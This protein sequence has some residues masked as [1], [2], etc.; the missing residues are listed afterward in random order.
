MRR[1]GIVGLPNAGKTTLFNALTRAGAHAAAHPFTT[2]DPNTGVVDVP[3]ARLEGLA[4]VVGPEK[5]LRAQ[6]TFVDIAGLVRG[7]HRGE[8]L[9]NRF[10][11][12]VRE[13]DALLHVVRC[14]AR[15]DVP[16]V[17]GRVDPASDVETVRTEL[18]L[19]D[20]EAVQGRLG[21]AGKRARLAGDAGARREVALLEEAEAALSRGEPAPAP[22]PDVP[23]LSSKPTVYVANVSEEDAGDPAAWEERVAAV[24]NGAFVIGLCAQLEAEAAELPPGE[25]AEVLSA[26][27]LGEPALPRAVQACYRA[28]DLVTFFTVESSICQAWTVPRGTRAPQAAGRI[29]TD[30]ERGFVRAEVV[31]VSSLVEAGSFGAAR[32]RG[33]VRLEGRDYVVADGD[34]I[35]FKFAA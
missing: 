8:G 18:A 17:E 5:V 10:L 23:L 16:H 20:L 33:G 29:H 22:P 6:V 25:Q 19:A 24:A 13:M 1:V 26:Y 11:A 21:R 34:V 28:L 27:G 30:F 7:A 9:G 35:L 12:H 15:E 2:I 32:E 14:F 4:S 3:D 31:P